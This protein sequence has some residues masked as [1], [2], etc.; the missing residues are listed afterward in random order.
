MRTVKRIAGILFGLSVLLVLGLGAYGYWG[1]EQGA[2]E[3]SSLTTLAAPMMTKQTTGTNSDAQAD[4]NKDGLLERGAYLVKQANCAGCHTAIGGKA[5]AG[6]RILRS[7]FGDF[8]TPNISPDKTTGIGTWSADEFWRALHNG[9]GKDG[10]LLYPAFPFENYTH[11][12][13]ADADAMWAYLQTVPAVQ[14]SNPDHQLRSPYDQRWMLA[15][16]RAL[17]FRPGALHYEARE[18]AAWNRGAYLVRG[19]A[20]CSACHS[21]RDRLGGSK[22]SGDLSGANPQGANWYAPSLLDASDSEVGTTEPKALER[23]L[24]QGQNDQRAVLGTMAEVVQQSLQAWRDDDI[25]AMREYLQQQARTKK[26]ASQKQEDFLDRSLKRSEISADQMQVLL[27]QGEKIYRQ[28]CAE[29][30]AD[31]GR[32]RAGVYPRL[33]GSAAVQRAN[34]GNLIRVILAG[35]Y[36]PVTQHQPRPFGMPPFAP[37]LSD[38]EV[39]LVATY[40][41]NSWG[42]KA[43]PVS[44]SEVNPYRSVAI[45]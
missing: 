45:D 32:G 3:A 41:R 39:A 35:G 22:G 38:D 1:L 20:H 43:S 5:F 13:R 23:L 27:I 15:W 42:N 10:R 6:G 7:E 16:W 17:N 30:H 19:L 29:C 40:I 21:A 4:S 14:Q 33:Q 28:H 37:F 2:N 18:S 12:T 31:D 34:N 24:H 9:K 11:I 44:A 8:V 26:V 25:A 36:P